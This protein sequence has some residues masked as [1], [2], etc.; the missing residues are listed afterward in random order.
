MMRYRTM[1]FKLQ[2]NKSKSTTN[3]PVLWHTHTLKKVQR[4]TRWRWIV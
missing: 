1:T 2:P 3:D 4:K